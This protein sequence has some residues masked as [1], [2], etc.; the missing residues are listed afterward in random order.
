M[1]DHDLLPDLLARPVSVSLPDAE[2]EA[3][4][5]AVA[6]HV[7][8]GHGAHLHKRQRALKTEVHRDL[9]LE[10]DLQLFGHAEVSV[11]VADVSSRLAIWYNKAQSYTQY[12]MLEFKHVQYNHLQARLHR[13]TPRLRVRSTESRLIVL[14]TASLL[15]KDYI[16]QERRLSTSGTAC[17]SSSRLPLSHSKLVGRCV[18]YQ[19]SH[20]AVL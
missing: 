14:D 3:W 12:D 16:S 2:M 10:E 4:H 8:L 20:Y 18:R 1:A 7:L 17:I 19:K 11:W 6:V 13:P 5:V 15:I 9:H